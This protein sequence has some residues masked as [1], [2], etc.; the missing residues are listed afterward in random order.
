MQ[1][2][3]PKPPNDF[4]PIKNENLLYRLYVI[5]EVRFAFQAAATSKW[6]T[7]WIYKLILGGTASWWIAT[8]WLY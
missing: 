6:M 7:W 5:R 4:G 2:H 8:H 1:N 3:P